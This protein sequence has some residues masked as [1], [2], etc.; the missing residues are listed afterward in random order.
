MLFTGVLQV[1]REAVKVK[2]AYSFVARIRNG[3]T[4]KTIS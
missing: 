1:V 3:H 4:R 2:I